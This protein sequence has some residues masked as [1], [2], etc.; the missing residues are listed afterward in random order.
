MQTR[1]EI[2]TELTN[3]LMIANNSTLFSD[4]RKITV[5]QDAYLWAGSLFFWPS[6]FKSMIFSSEPN[7]QNLA[8]DYYDYPTNML[9]GSIS[10]LYING[11]KYEEKAFQDFLDYT[12]NPTDDPSIQDTNKR[13]FAKFGRQYF[14][15][16]TVSV[17]G[18][19]DGL[20]WGNVQ[21][22]ALSTGIT[23][24]IFSLWD[25]SGNEAILK[26][27]LGVLTERLEPSFA[28]AQKQEAIQ[29]LTLMWQKIVTENQKAQRL[30]HPRFN[31]QDMFASGVSSSNIANFNSI[32]VKF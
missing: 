24:T 22:D 18:S 6:L 16:P 31:V 20:L 15:W 21:P 26:K 2:V 5:V 19:G 27:A 14:V 3:R 28:A 10:R 25:D 32:D 30:Q 11:K 12:D 17:A 13:Y 23:K 1:D 9:T 29:L 8:Y 4:S 7:S